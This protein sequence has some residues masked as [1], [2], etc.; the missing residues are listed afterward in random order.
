MI[1]FYIFITSYFFI[2]LFKQDLKKFY[3]LLPFLTIN[4]VIIFLYL[5]VDEITGGG[6]TRSFW[7]HLNFDIK[8][9]TYN[10]YL[11]SFLINFLLLILAISIALFLTFRFFKYKKINIFKSSI[12]LLLVNP[13]FYSLALSYFDWKNLSSNQDRNLKISNYFYDVKKP[14]IKFDKR[15]LIFISVESF[16]RTFY[17]IE[18]PQKIKFNLLNR[19]DIYDFNNIKQ[20]ENYTDWT[21]AGLVAATLGAP[22]DVV[23]TRIMNQPL[24]PYV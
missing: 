9:G 15:D 13:A 6:F 8:S 7:Y 23:K 2:N 24:D 20:I 3:L 5:F 1:F 14:N 19:E 21:I 4:I 16:E 12:I 11:L 18:L 17:E 22:A 10:P